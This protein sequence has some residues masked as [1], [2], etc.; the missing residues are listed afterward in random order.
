MVDAPF[1]TPIHG[2]PVATFD[3]AGLY[4]MVPGGRGIGK[5]RGAEGNIAHIEI[6]RRRK[7]ELSAAV[8]ADEESVG[9]EFHGADV[10]VVIELI[11][12][13]PEIGFSTQMRLGKGE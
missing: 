2:V 9:D 4:E 1:G 5:V 8:R 6:R 10:G 3:R 11:A 7:G 12:I 13:D